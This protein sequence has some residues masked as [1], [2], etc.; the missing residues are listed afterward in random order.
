MTL[1]P[2]QSS[3]R[4]AYFSARES[5]GFS[6]HQAVARMLEGAS[7]SLSE[8]WTQQPHLS[9]REAVTQLPSGHAQM[10][11]QQWQ[12][13]F[14]ALENLAQ[15][16][17][18]QIFYSDLLSLAGDLER[19]EH[20]PMAMQIYQSVA[21]NSQ[22]PLTLRHQAQERLAPYQG[23]GSLG[24]R[25]ELW[26]GQAVTGVTDPYM[27]MGMGVGSLAFRA[28]R[29]MALRPMVGAGRAGIVVRSLATLSGVASETLAFT[30]TV[31]ALRTLGGHQE[32]WGLEALGHESAA[33][34]LLLG[35]LRLVGSPFKYLSRG[36]PHAPYF[37]LAGTYGGIV[38]G[39]GLGQ[40]TGLQTPQSVDNLL[41]QS[42]VTLVQ[43]QGAGALMRTVLGPRLARAESV[44]DQSMRRLEQGTP[45]AW[46]RLRSFDWMPTPQL[47]TPQGEVFSGKSIGPM[48]VTHNM[49]VA[50][51][52]RGGTSKRPLIRPMS[53]GVPRPSGRSPEGVVMS[54]EAREAKIRELL[55]R[56]RVEYYTASGDWAQ[57]TLEAFGI[58][59]HPYDRQL[60]RAGV[61]LGTKR[62][63]R[64][65]RIAWDVDEVLLHWS[66]NPRD[67][68]RGLGRS[69]NNPNYTNT[70]E[71]VLQYEAFRANP[72]Y[73]MSRG[74][75]LFYQTLQSA[76]PSNMRQHIQF[77]PGMRA[78]LLG[79]KIGQGRPLIMAT[80]G[81]AG[82]ILI[83]ANEDAAFKQ[84]FFS[85]L[86]SEPVSIDE[87]RRRPNIYTREDLALAL[88]QIHEGEIVFPNDPMV[89]D[90]L[91]RLQARPESALK[92]KHPALARLR[93]KRAFSI[94]VDDSSSAYQSLH[95]LAGFAVLKPPSAR[96][97]TLLNFTL[98]ST[99]RYLDRMSN[100]YAQNLANLLAA[101][102]PIRSQEIESAPRPAYYEHQ[103][104]AIDLPWQRF[105]REF[106]EPA[107]EVLALSRRVNE[108]SLPALGESTKVTRALR[109][110]P[111][112]LEALS[113][114]LEREILALVDGT[115][116]RVKS[117][118]DS[119][120]ELQRRARENPER[121]RL[122]LRHRFHPDE[123]AR[124]DLLR[125][126]LAERHL[127]FFSTMAGVLSAKRAVVDLLGLEVSGNLPLVHF[128][129]GQPLVY[130]EVAQALGPG[131]LI[132]SQTSDGEVGVGLALYEPVRNSS[133]ITSLGIDMTTARLG[134][135]QSRLGVTPEHHTLTESAYKATLLQHP[136]RQFA[137]G[138]YEEISSP[139]LGEEMGYQG[140]FQELGQD[141]RILTGK[142]AGAARALMEV[143]ESVGPLRIVGRNF[144]VG[145]A[146]VGLVA[147]PH[148]KSKS[149]TQFLHSTSGE[150][151]GIGPQGTFEFLRP[152]LQVVVL[153]DIGAS[154]TYAIAAQGHRPVHIDYAPFYMRA[155][156]RG[157]NRFNRRNINNL[158][159]DREVFAE[160]ISGD[161]FKTRLEAD[162]VEAYFP[163]S[164]MDLPRYLGPEYT[165]AVRN[166]MVQALHTK[167]RSQNGHVFVISELPELIRTI[168][169]I[170][171]SE[172]EAKIIDYAQDEPGAPLQGG[173][174]ANSL[175]T[176][177]ESWVLYQLK[178]E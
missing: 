50:L 38:L 49:M 178:G 164:V 76:L 128:R 1:I 151:Y 162:A 6:G 126:P 61:Q 145:D 148:I 95:D 42:L 166:F 104:F 116:T 87:V 64:V 115:S 69:E 94:L 90:Y 112:Q 59:S 169:E 53:I 108:L 57:E 156:Q 100:G 130:G 152:N 173:H 89:R 88:R 98:G 117:Y 79:L 113:E 136:N 5:S 7:G 93:G 177:K 92:L 52:N 160:W 66:M 43:F 32:D 157:F 159:M 142:T 47:V 51:P 70:P 176:S 137:K 54:A 63:S 27:L 125:R 41:L 34:A 124:F 31:K 19:G 40:R 114:R 25:L 85:K 24:S 75:R 9:L 73:P 153:G 65:E 80:T 105:G 21:E 84:I 20:G 2:P 140:E 143:P 111:R 170:A 119:G 12:P 58:T 155:S 129:Y 102:G 46:S 147:I 16:Q 132:T 149:S 127:K 110:R 141:F 83:L 134:R 78:F 37:H 15:E 131:R 144:N 14:N 35:S 174:N 29:L 30:G 74:K 17:D 56:G 28:G 36:S 86:P 106:H 101:E 123:L 33:T 26:T 121:F 161:W 165:R 11:Q 163:L 72:D 77:H 135:V 10:L 23:E 55:P 45:N 44:L 22:A 138:R 68:F 133:G 71:S 39:H 167:V 109:L 18:S 168:S 172:F 175:P 60:F 103:R 48:E 107:A 171:T 4:G 154:R 67:A 82:R 62:A 122:F 99:Q 146:I 120:P 3:L 150:I 96:P 139:S 118:T 81:P 13:A 158:Q 97:A 91:Q 8:L